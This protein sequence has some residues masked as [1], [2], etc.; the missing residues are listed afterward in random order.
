MHDACLYDTRFFV[1]YFYSDDPELVGKLKQELRTVK[2]RMVSSL[3]IHEIY[4]INL[5]N[6]GRDVAALRSNTIRGD[7]EVIDVNYKIAVKSADLRSIHQM[8]MADS[9]IA[10]TAQ[11]HKCPVFSDDPH[12]REIQDLKTKWCKK[13]Q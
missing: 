11:I 8:P 7:F 4:R 3:T 5:K 2:E 9:I 1:E 13:Q 10:A 12:F 6:Q